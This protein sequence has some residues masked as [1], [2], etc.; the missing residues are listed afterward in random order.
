MPMH[1]VACISIVALD[2]RYCLTDDEI[3]SHRTMLKYMVL[4][5]NFERACTHD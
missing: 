3:A 4:N 5:M 2:Y 1:M